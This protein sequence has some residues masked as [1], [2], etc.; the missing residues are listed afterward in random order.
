MP[1][2]PKEINDAIWGTIKLQPLEVIILDSPLVQRLRFVRQLGVVHWIYPG[3]VHTRFEHTLGVLHQAHALIVAI[4]EAT[5]APHSPPIDTNYSAIVRLC[6]LLHD[7]GHGVFSHVSEHAIA[8]RSDVG[9]ALQAFASL[10]GLGKVQ[11]TE[12]IAYYIV[13]SGSFRKLLQVAVEALGRP[14]G[15]AADPAENG[16]RIAALIQNSI[17]GKGISSKVPLLHELISGP[18]DA[19]KLDYFIRDARLAGVPTMLDMSRL[20][21]KIAV[22]VMAARDLP[23]HIAASVEAGQPAYYLFGLKW[24][25][26]AVLDELHLAR[27]FLYAKIYRHHKVMAAEAMVEALFEAM[28]QLPGFNTINLVELAY[29][30]SDDQLL[31]SEPD[32]IA[33]ALGLSGEPSVPLTFVGQILSKLRNRRM[34][35]SALSVRPTYTGDPWG[36][37]KAQI[38]GLR[39]LDEEL[40]HPQRAPEF[41]EALVAELRHVI[42]L[43]P[44]L[45]P[46]IDIATI[47]F[48]LVI[49][50]KTRISGGTEIDRAFVFQAGKTIQY[51][52]ISGV[53]RSAWVD[54]YGFSA[55]SALVF[56]PRELSVATYI[57]AEKLL[58]E[59]YGVILPEGAME[60]SKQLPQHILEC[61]RVLQAKGYYDRTP[62]DIRPQPAR[63]MKADIS[64][65]LDDMCAKF[66]AVDE[67]GSSPDGRRAATLRERILAWLAQFRDDDDVNCAMTV[68]RAVR[69]LGREDTRKAL[70][71]FVSQHPEFKG[72]T[73]VVLGGLKDSSVLQAYYSRD[74]PDIFSHVTTLEDAAKRD[75]A[76]PVVFLDDFIGS[77]GQVQD[78]LGQGFNMEELKQ[79][80]LDEQRQ[81]FGEQELIYLRSR[82]IGFCFVAGWKVGSDALESACSK[83]GLDAIVHIDIME[84]QIPFTFENV[85]CE[86][87]DDQVEHFRRTCEHTGAE[88]LR[89]AGKDEKKVAE[90]ALGYGNRAML[91]IS[92]YNVPSQVLT[93]F[94]HD[95]E[96]DGAEWQPLLSRRQ[97]T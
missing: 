88:L 29:Q 61:K 37:D 10:H 31:W 1:R 85:L 71:G 27:V 70:T 96:V 3:A 42:E 32:V 22:R 94:W 92:R 34:F 47:N 58:R 82:K 83:I 20:I 35:V 44:E 23:L 25:G 60:L 63:L 8:Q 80:H 7:I 53:N 86:T 62:F 55:A 41:R 33:N 39:R 91:L 73:V 89:S 26:Q 64:A 45:A 67:P 16:D 30:F 74:V 78:I 95:G 28:S 5:P 75:L 49:S 4:N 97:K 15:L 84:D 24:S 87:P 54:A 9:P 43:S 2:I 11:L 17:V 77:G 56:T 65:F 72:A 48:N 38:R 36:E 79:E 50:A 6:A 69:V 52:D 59:R 76:G 46:G 68:L 66:E 21:Q 18:F 81:L 51:R 93:C 57:A 40:K 19:D 13:G 90:R 14:I 12:V